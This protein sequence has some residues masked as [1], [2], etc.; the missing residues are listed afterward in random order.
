MQVGVQLLILR[1]VKIICE[2]TTF[3]F[4]TIKPLQVEG[5]ENNSGMSQSVSDPGNI[6]RASLETT[7]AARPDH[8]GRF[9]FQLSK[10]LILQLN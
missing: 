4:G 1:T 7:V 6:N 9:E 2:Q 5:Q 8:F 3:G 10:I